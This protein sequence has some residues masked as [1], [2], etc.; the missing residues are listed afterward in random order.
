MIPVLLILIPLFGGLVA[1]FMKQEKAARAWSLLIAV[2]GLII[3]L[4]GLLSMKT[5]KHL[6]VDL[7]WLQLLNS[8]FAVG[9]DG[10]GQVLCL[11]TAIAFPI[12]FLATWNTTYKKANNFYALMLLSQA[13][14]FGV[15]LAM[16][17]LLF[18]FFWEL[19]LIP[20][21]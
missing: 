1:F 10:I 3:S 12:I 5:G 19:A 20:A 14:L 7:P 18:Y 6:S 17:A 16:D 8:R 2:A 11:L 13:G 15:F 4:I 21:Y 9:L